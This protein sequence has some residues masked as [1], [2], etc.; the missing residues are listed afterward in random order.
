MRAMRIK[1]SLLA[2]SSCFVV[3]LSS[4][5][6]FFLQISRFWGKINRPD[7]TMIGHDS[8]PRRKPSRKSTL[9]EGPCTA[10]SCAVAGAIF[11]ALTHGPYGATT[12][13]RAPA[14]CG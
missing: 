3:A 5:F 11:P 13:K 10:R 12:E 1:S 14:I 2:F 4:R 9:V 7:L 8:R 6:S